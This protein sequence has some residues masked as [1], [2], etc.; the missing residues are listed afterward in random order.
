MAS[1]CSSGPPRRPEAALHAMQVGP[2]I[3]EIEDEA[4]L[5]F[6]HGTAI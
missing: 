6:A 4:I 2:P 1:L 3:F 5:G